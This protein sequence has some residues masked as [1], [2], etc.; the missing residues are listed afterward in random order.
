VGML[1]LSF[2][3]Y[4]ERPTWFL[5]AWLG[6]TVA[7]TVADNFLPVMMT[8]RFGGSRAATVGTIVGMVVGLFFGPLGMIVGPFAGAF[9]GEL[10]GNRS[11]GRVA[12]RV[13]TGAFVAFICGTGLKLVVSGIML[14]LMVRELI[15]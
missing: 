14:Y 11:E 15:A 4:W 3:A 10:V 8:R 1:L 5:I 6:V 7:V 12:L 13:A 2:T 9:A